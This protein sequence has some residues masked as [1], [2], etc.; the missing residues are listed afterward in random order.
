M[1][2]TPKETIM[3][4]K[5]A[6]LLA[7]FMPEYKVFFSN[8]G[9]YDLTVEE[10][11]ENIRFGVEVV[12]PELMKTPE[13][14][15]YID[16][17]SE[18][19]YSWFSERLPILLICFDSDTETLRW[20]F[21]VSWDKEEPTINH[22]VDWKNFNENTLSDLLPQLREQSPMARVLE[23]KKICLIKRIYV[24]REYAGQTHKAYFCYLRKFTSDYKMQEEPE[25]LDEKEKF[26]R[27]LNGIP[28]ELYPRDLLDDRIMDA[29]SLFCPNLMMKSKV[30]LINKE[31][32]AFRAEVSSPHRNFQVVI[33]PDV[34]TIPIGLMDMVNST[35]VLSIP[36]QLFYSPHH[37]I[38]A[39]RE[40]YAT[41]SLPYE[42]WSESYNKLSR[43]R[44]E[45]LMD[46]NEIL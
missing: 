42:V 10:P 9:L 16:T 46:I 28:E 21:L 29:I 39:Y 36:I 7:Q 40:S 24:T 31:L 13:F 38:D 23:D 22:M 44:T 1:N 15:Q 5:A 19:K 6:M 43:L 25:E 4:K 17:I 20:H 8:S 35:S 45:T 34:N 33:V 3:C 11:F 12:T 37:E 2:R 30:M 41:L 32:Q 14:K 27:L 18:Y 26:N